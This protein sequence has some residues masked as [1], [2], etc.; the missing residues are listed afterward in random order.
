M[1]YL[2]VSTNARRHRL[3]SIDYIKTLGCHEEP[4]VSKDDMTTYRFFTSVS[5]CA[6]IARLMLSETGTPTSS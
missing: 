3:I 4:L 1:R 2:P 6:S 5:K